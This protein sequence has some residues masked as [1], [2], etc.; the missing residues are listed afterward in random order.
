MGHEFPAIRF[1]IS[2][3]KGMHHITGQAYNAKLSSFGSNGP[4]GERGDMSTI[5]TLT[6]GY[7]APEDLSTGKHSNVNFGVPPIL[8]TFACLGSKI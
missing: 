6:H 3:L 4:T 1:Y 2:I 8:C 5:A 7:A